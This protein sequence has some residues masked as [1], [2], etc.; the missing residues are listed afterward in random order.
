MLVNIFRYSDCRM[1]AEKK[2]FSSRT[3]AENFCNYVAQKIGG[4]GNYFYNLA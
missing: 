3:A 4:K 2:Y 1:V